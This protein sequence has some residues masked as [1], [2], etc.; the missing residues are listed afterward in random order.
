[1]ASEMYDVMQNESVKLD[2]VLD[3]TKFFLYTRS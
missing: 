2:G 1:M 3:K